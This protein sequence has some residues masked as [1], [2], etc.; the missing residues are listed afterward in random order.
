MKFTK[1]EA[2]KRRHFRVR[3][4]VIGTAEKPRLNVFKSNTNF[5][6]QIIDDVAGVTL[7]SA[8]TMKTSLKSKSNIEAAVTVAN[9]IAKKA[10]AAKIEEVVFDRG[11]YQYH[12]KVKAF[13]DAAREAGLKF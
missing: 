1:Q 2:R 4:K 12:G 6:A 7:I 9:E 3:K 5:Y 10:K 8:S 13:A 11:G